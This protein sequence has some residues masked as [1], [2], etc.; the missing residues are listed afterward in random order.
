M[1]DISSMQ[2]AINNGE[3]PMQFK[4]LLA[5]TITLQYHSSAE[6]DL[7]QSHFEKTVQGKEAPSEIT[8]VVI[9]QFQMRVLDIVKA[10]LPD[11]SSSNLRRLIE[12]GGVELLH[13]SQR[14]TDPNQ[15]VTLSSSSIVRVGKRKFF[16]F[17]K[18][19]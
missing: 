3:N 14:P 19:V 7:A 8:V 16:Q 6:A 13:E 9:P 12:Q 2:A 11:E 4:K 1:S 5:W 10:A 15:M 17:K 18:S